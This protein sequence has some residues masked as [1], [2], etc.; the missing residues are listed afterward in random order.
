MTR[1]KILYFS[2]G[3]HISCSLFAGRGKTGQYEL[4]GQFICNPREFVDLREQLNTVA[5]ENRMKT[6]E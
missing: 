3:V 6:D 4:L 2:T 5:F 1:F